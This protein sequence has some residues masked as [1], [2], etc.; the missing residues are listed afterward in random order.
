MGIIKPTDIQ[1]CKNF[2]ADLDESYSM[3]VMA[4]HVRLQNANALSCW[5]KRK[6]IVVVAL[7]KASSLHYA[8]Y[9]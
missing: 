1:M 4:T 8:Y 9:S 3:A 2:E 7:A 5:L 6:S